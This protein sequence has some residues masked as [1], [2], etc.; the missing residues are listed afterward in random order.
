MS[1]TKK[2]KINI[3]NEKGEVTKAAEAKALDL[4]FGSIR[5]IMELLKIE[6]AGN[7]YDLLRTIYGV[8]DEL[9]G[10]LSE[11]FPEIKPEEWDGVKMNELLPAVALIA[12]ESFAA[13]LTIPTEKNE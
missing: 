5:K 9:T 4:R 1:E 13:M 6:E 10:I 2:I 12:K 7:T 11:C 8:W 3:Y